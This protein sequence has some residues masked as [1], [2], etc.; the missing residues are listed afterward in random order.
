MLH[1]YC[2]Y[3]CLFVSRPVAAYSSNVHTHRIRCAIRSSVSRSVSAVLA[4][5][6]D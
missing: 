4:C 2:V 1:L 3:H 6:F 5:L